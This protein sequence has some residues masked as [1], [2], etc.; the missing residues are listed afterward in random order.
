MALLKTKKVELI[1][2]FH[3]G[4]QDTGSSPVQIALLTER[5]NLLT[6]HFKMHKS[7]HHSRVGLLRLV[8]KR[9]RLLDYLKKSDEGKYK[10]VVDK[11]KLRK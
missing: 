8:S 5:I 7:D 6:D 1:K 3:V 10:E 9:R 11:L 2:E 4:E